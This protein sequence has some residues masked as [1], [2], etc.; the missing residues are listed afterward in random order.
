[1]EWMIVAFGGG[2]GA[3][4]RYLVQLWVIKLRISTYW[5]TATVNVLG[6]FIL[7]ITTNI[8]IDSST[9]LAFLTVGVLGGFTTF[10]TFA[11]DFVK[12]FETKKWGTSLLFVGVNLIGGIFAFWVGWLI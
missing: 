7:G 4:L 6:S 3:T 10:S 1:M 12:L 9:M 11:F 2:I 5:S 8:A